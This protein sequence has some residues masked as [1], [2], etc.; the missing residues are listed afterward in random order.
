M[1][2]EPK[3]EQVFHKRFIWSQ[4]DKTNQ[5][6]YVVYFRKHGK[7]PAG[8]T[9]YKPFLTAYQFTTQTTN[10]FMVRTFLDIGL[11]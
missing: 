9:I 3:K 2:G 10:Q 1:S 11:N 8:G 7:N 4:F 5:R 6:L